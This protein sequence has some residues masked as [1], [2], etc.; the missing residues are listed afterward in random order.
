MQFKQISIENNVMIVLL[1]Q[2]LIHIISVEPQLFFAKLRVES[3]QSF[4][5]LIVEF[6]LCRCHGGVDGSL[7]WTVPSINRPNETEPATLLILPFWTF[8]RDSYFLFFIWPFYVKLP[9]FNFTLQFGNNSGQVEI[10]TLKNSQND[11]IENVFTGN[12][13]MFKC[14]SR[15]L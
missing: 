9:S 10:D 3:N 8:F 1:I 11:T 4:A 5:C 12:Q 6:C 7:H 14:C 13:D 2:S 15:Y